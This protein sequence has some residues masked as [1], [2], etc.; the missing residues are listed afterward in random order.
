M[1]TECDKKERI[2]CKDASQPRWKLGI[3]GHAIWWRLPQWRAMRK[4]VAVALWGDACVSHRATATTPSGVFHPSS[5]AS[6]W[7]AS[8]RYRKA[9][10]RFRFSMRSSCCLCLIETKT[11]VQERDAFKNERTGAAAIPILGAGLAFG[12]VS[13]RIC[14]DRVRASVAGWIHLG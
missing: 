5:P 8:E 4:D 2:V 12:A 14:F 10:I 3:I 13:N 11:D 6:A 9:R 7:Q 1:R